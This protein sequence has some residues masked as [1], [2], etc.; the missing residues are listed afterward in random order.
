MLKLKFS[1][2][3]VVM[4]MIMIMVLG[5]YALGSEIK[6]GAGAAP[7]EN[8]LKPVKEPFEK[9]TG[10]KLTIIP[11][12]PKNALIDLDRGLTDAA[13]AGLTL[14]DWMDLMEKDGAKVKDMASLQQITIGKDM[15]VV[16]HHKNNPVSKLSQEQLKG[17]FSGKITNWKDAGGKD[18]PITVVW[19]KLIPGTNSLFERRI[20]DGNTPK[21]NIL[22]ATTADDIKQKVTSNPGAIGIGPSGIV[23]DTVKSPETPEISRPIIMITKGNPSPNTLKL[24]DYIKGEG[25]R[26]IKQ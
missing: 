11:S 17:I 20:L 15:I 4:I 24:V 18:M 13:A 10:I 14:Q 5:T 22:E 6:I 9:A 8:I 23:D 21:G 26:Y 3:P 7:V 2:I 12:G 19:G 16:I 25:Q 1:L